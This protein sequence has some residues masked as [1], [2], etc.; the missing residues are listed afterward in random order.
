MITTIILISIL[1][2]IQLA[3]AWYIMSMATNM[4]ILNSKLDE[5]YK[6]VATAEKKKKRVSK[7]APIGFKTSATE[8]EILNRKK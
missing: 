7:K 6:I 5:L 3:T 8:A 1:G 4:I 2:L